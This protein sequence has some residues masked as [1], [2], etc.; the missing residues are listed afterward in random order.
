M[1]ERRVERARDEIELERVTD[2]AG[3]IELQQAVERVH[4]SEA[5]GY[6]LV[7]LAA[8]T[9]ASAR[10]QV[11]ASPRGT[12]AL[13]KLSR[14]HAALRGRD[15]VTPEDVKAVAVQALAHRLMLRPE[16][17]VQRIKPEDVVRE[18]LDTV[19]T[20]AAEDV[21]GRPA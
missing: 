10:L 3:V 5:V 16:L 12:L 11:G 19:P 4:V 1:L 21:A 17:W 15:Y 8:A 20:P 9:R 2:R 7:D 13:L 14:A 6:Y 18:T